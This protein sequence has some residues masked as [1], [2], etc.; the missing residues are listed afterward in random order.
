MFWQK[1][2]VQQVA[3]L[4][5]LARVRDWRI[6]PWRREG[7]ESLHAT[8]AEN[9]KIHFGLEWKACS[10]LQGQQGHHGANADLSCRKQDF[11]HGSKAAV[12]ERTPGC[13]SPLTVV[14]GADV[15]AEKRWPLVTCVLMR[16]RGHELSHD[17]TPSWRHELSTSLYFFIKICFLWTLLSEVKLKEDTISGNV[18][19]C[20]LRCKPDNTHDLNIRSVF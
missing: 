13:S 17:F 10:L 6:P 15:K 4:T 3:H 11:I 1:Q 9:Q 20:Q 12:K 16:S 14:G 18:K 19:F 2:Y 8:Y 7:D 5:L